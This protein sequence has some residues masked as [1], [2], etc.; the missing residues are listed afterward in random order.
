M[1]NFEGM[2]GRICRGQTEEDFERMA[3]ASR[4][5]VFLMGS[6]GLEEIEPLSDYE[7]LIKIGYERDY[8]KQK[9]DQGFSFR[10]VHFPSKQ[11][12]V[13]CSMATWDGALAVVNNVYPKAG[14]LVEK[15]LPALKNHEFS[16]HQDD[17]PFDMKEADSKG[18]A[19]ENFITEERLLKSKGDAAHTRAFLYHTM[20]LRALYH[21]DG[22][23]RTA[24]GTKGIKE[25]LSPNVALKDLKGV[26]IK[27]L[28]VQMPEEGKDDSSAQGAPQLTAV[29]TAAADEWAQVEKTEEGRV[30]K[31]SFLKFQ[32]AKHAAKLTP[33]T[34]PAFMEFLYRVFAAGTGLMLP[35]EKN[36]IRSALF[37]LLFPVSW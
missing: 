28:D 10:Q 4:L 29:Q 11:E 6:D 25:Y 21:G 13:P 36:D 19:H 8:I 37:L 22:Y 17:C 27:K 18:I 23:T 33:E 7:K 24:D 16:K 9:L 1:S 30:N 12:K 15:H 34:T 3:E 2:C 14:E 32:L 35:V 31:A 5:V 26:V 20:Q